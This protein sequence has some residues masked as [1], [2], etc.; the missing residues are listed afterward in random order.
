MN[1]INSSRIYMRS[2]AT[3]ESQTELSSAI[4]DAIDVVKAAGFDLVFVE[5]SGIGQGNAGVVGIC[6]VSL[7]V[8]TCEFGAPTQLEKIDML[9]FADLV[10]INKFE[11]KGAEDAL[12]NVRKQYR[13]NRNL[14]D[15]ADEAL[16]VFGT[17]ASQFNDPGTNV[18]Y[19]ALLDTVNAK[20]GSSWQSSLQIT[21]KESLKKYI[22]PP[23]RVHYLGEI[24]HAVRGYR[25]QVK[26]Q[27]A[28]ARRLFQLN[29][30]RE[31]L[32]ES[33]AVAELDKQIALFECQAAR[34]AE[35][36]TE[37]VARTEGFLPPRPARDKSQ[38]Q[39][40]QERS[41]YHNP[42]RHPD[43][44]GLSPRFCRLGRDSPLEHAGERAGL[45]PVHCRGVPL[46]AGRRG[47]QAPVCRRRYT[48]ADQPPLSLPLQ[49]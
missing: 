21:E 26:E 4:Q 6:D 30:A 10:A 14:F 1:A 11:R 29:G 16:P 38:G 13:R 42:F 17:I 41:L 37:G 35:K 32:A 15:V 19:L 8:M 20:K 2:L 22:I 43:S 12:R 45:F 48:G 36:D 9:D 25:R 39:G 28:V 7:Y 24:V 49:G 18:L 3:R 5:T 46:Q 44:Q 33:A 31:V 23:D 40:D 34:G 27:S 47:S